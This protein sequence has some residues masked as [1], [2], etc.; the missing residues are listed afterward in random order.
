MTDDG[1][2]FVTRYETQ[3]EHPN[4]FL[5]K[6]GDPE[7]KPLTDIKDPAKSLREVTKK[8]ISYSR[9]D[10]VKLN[11]MLHLPPGYDLSDPDRKR[12]PT[13][14]WAYPRAYTRDT[15]AGQVANSPHRFSTFAGAS[16]RFL[17]LE[18]Y[19]VLDQVAM[20]IVGDPETA[21]D[22]FAEQ[23]VD[24][25]EAVIDA[26]VEMGVCDRNR[27]GVGGHSY[28]GFM[29][30]MLLANSTLF[31]AGVARSGAF[32]RTLTPFGFQNERRT[33][34]QA[35]DMYLEMSPLLAVPKIR[36]PLLLIHG[37][38][39]NNPA[40]TPDQTRQLYR[41][42][43]GNGGKARIVMLPHESHTYQARESVG[44][45]LREMV[46]WFDKHVKGDPDNP[47]EPGG[48]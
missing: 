44:H 2:E 23:I 32:N 6:V 10:G 38:E 36:D 35:P 30:V 13:I 1:Q 46:K 48:S 47:E 8:L 14:L 16:P 43:K 45:V 5:R 37:E 39:D 29:A 28:G 12:L 27:V 21:N 31:R 11:C 22:T 33:L 41:A 15:V 24:N 4:Y 19:A 3:T 42:V 7:R 20:P 17:A 34:W 18:G 26:V 9:D 25:A 40:T